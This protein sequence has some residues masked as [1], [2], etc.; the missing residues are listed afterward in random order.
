MAWRLSLD[1]ADVSDI[2]MHV[3]NLNWF[4][5]FSIGIFLVGATALTMPRGHSVGFYWIVFSALMYW[6]SNKENFLS[7][8]TKKF[9]YPLLAYAFGNMGLGLNESFEWYKLDP[10]LPFVLFLPSLWALRKTK[11]SADWFWRGLAFGAMGAAVIAGYQALILGIRAEGFS[12]AIQFGN[13]ALLLGILCMLRAMLSLEDEKT[14]ALLWLGFASGL[15][16]SVWS[17]TRGGWV[18]IALIFIWILVK[19]THHYSAKK[20]WLTIL[21]LLSVLAIPVLQ[22]GGIVQTRV[23]GAVTDFQD[24]I[25]T[26]NQNGSVGIRFAMWRVSAQQ[27]AKTPWLGVSDRGWATL[28]TEAIEDGRLDK[29]ASGF[30]HVHNEF[31]D[32]ALKRG[33]VGLSLYL[34]MYLVPMLYFFKPHLTHPNLE[35]RSYAMAGMV[36]PM[37][38]MDFA[39]T[40]GFLSHNSGRMMLVSLWM[41]VAA[42]MLNALD[43]YNKAKGQPD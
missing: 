20:R 31:L 17:Q 23:S 41:C 10:Y 39:L 15:T 32:V 5:I 30:D 8:D 21:T 37:M 7:A 42:F 4:S 6:L 2:R 40:Q 25:K 43:Q 11:P 34:A 26:G 24:Y 18:A 14:N 9:T 19:S 29:F 16:A 36:I 33:L 22:P 27:I 1:I 35:V 28:R 3:K 38:F 12:H 13:L